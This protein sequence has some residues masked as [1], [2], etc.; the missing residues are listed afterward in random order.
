M[1]EPSS[2]P[3]GP[4]SDD[5]AALRARLGITVP[6][7][8]GAGEQRDHREELQQGS[9][10]STRWRMGWRS[11]LAGA[12]VLLVLS[13]LLL[14]RIQ[15]RGPSEVVSLSDFDMVVSQTGTVD[16]GPSQESTDLS[17]E[18]V[19]VPIDQ[20]APQV[21]VHV[22]GAVKRPG[23]IELPVNSRV[24][25]AI[26]AAGGAAKKADLT[27]INLARTI[28]DGEQLIVPLH[29]EKI[30]EPVPGLAGGSRANADGAAGNRIPVDINAGTAADFE[31]LPGIGPV[32]AERIVNHR[33]R[34]GTFGSVDD[35]AQ[36][37]GI[38]PAI[39]GQIRDLVRI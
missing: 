37:S 31:G 39:M 33:D 22:A 12:L 20:A 3:Q 8:R 4:Q 32:L 14:L 35:L 2:S 24:F 1:S 18:T 38:G 19:P 16:D 13:I 34:N 17:P 11:V 10:R 23:V 21:L 25:E 5:V 30:S 28:A 7:A 9:A 26:E 29:G 6:S 15:S 27:Q 36:V